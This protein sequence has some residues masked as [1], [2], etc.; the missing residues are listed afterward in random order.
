MN[1]LRSLL[2]SNPQLKAS[3]AYTLH[4]VPS[5]SQWI[6]A[7]HGRDLRD[8]CDFFDAWAVAV[9]VPSDHSA[10]SSAVV[11]PLGVGEV[12]GTHIWSELPTAVTFSVPMWSL[13]FSTGNAV[14]VRD[15]SLLSWLSEFFRAR[16]TFM[17]SAASWTAQV[18]AKWWARVNR[19]EYIVP[20]GGFGA[21]NGFFTRQIDRDYRPVDP[22][23]AYTPP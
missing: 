7:G 6:A 14:W 5:E 13:A 1:K 16:G 9:V 23:E 22:S 19:T 10:A 17:D 18:A 3:V 8:L 15:P 4:T 12:S 11:Q 20:A 2:S 21:F